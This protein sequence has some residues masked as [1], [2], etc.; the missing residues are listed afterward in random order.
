MRKLLLGEHVAVIENLVYWFCFF[1][2]I[3]LCKCTAK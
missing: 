1:V 2:F 3:S